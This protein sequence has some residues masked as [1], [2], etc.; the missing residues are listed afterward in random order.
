MDYV[1]ITQEDVTFEAG[2]NEVCIQFEITDDELVE[3]TEAVIFNVESAHEL[4]RA[5][6]GVLKI[7]DND[8]M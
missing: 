1:P 3:D 6:A 2:T 7:E 4:I 5:L 8:S